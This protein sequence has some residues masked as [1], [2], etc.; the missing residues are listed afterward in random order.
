MYAET[1]ILR[2]VLT[3]PYSKIASI[4]ITL[5]NMAAI[6]LG[7]YT[8]F[9]VRQTRELIAV[10]YQTQLIKAQGVV[11][12]DECDLPVWQLLE[13]IIAIA[14]IWGILRWVLPM[15][16]R[17]IV[18]KLGIHYV[19]VSQNP[20]INH[21]YSADIYIKIKGDRRTEAIYLCTVN[22]DPPQISS[23]GTGAQ[24][25]HCCKRI[26]HQH[27]THFNHSVARSG[28]VQLSRKEKGSFANGN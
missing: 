16:M 25:S 12:S 20:M 15:I 10:L 26:L 21:D 24:T 22:E 19:N 4:I 7:I 17:W 23:H 3:S 11:A 2:S 1:K 28:H 13:L 18:R 5:V 6:G 8:F 14:C 27:E 9:K